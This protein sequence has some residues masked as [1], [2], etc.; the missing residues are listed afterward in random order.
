[1]KIKHDR[2]ITTSTAVDGL[3]F[4]LSLCLFLLSNSTS[5]GHRTFTDKFLRDCCRFF[6]WSCRIAVKIHQ[7]SLMT[8]HKN[9]ISSINI[10]LFI[11]RFNMRLIKFSTKF[12]EIFLVSF[13][14]KNLILVF[15]FGHRNYNNS[16]LFMDFILVKMNMWDSFICIFRFFRFHRWISTR[17][18]PVWIFLLN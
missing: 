9:R 5:M 6:R 18:K 13:K 2:H 17:G 3:Y 10:Y 4:S 7:R 8:K 16:F 1:M 12:V 14:P 11:H 15:L